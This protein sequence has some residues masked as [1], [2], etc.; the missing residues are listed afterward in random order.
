MSSLL[1]LMH[2]TTS[3]RSINKEKN[4]MCPRRSMQ[5]KDTSPLTF[6]TGGTWGASPQ[7]S[8]P[9]RAAKEPIALKVTSPFPPGNKWQI[10]QNSCSGHTVQ[11][12]RP[13]ALAG[14]RRKRLHLTCL[15]T[16]RHGYKRLYEPSHSASKCVFL[17]QEIQI[18]FL[19]TVYKLMGLLSL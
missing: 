7:L 4:L 17:F 12:P 2:T 13:T 1:F 16:D 14:R 9:C 18:A 8:T 19:Y 11:R 6:C 3:N 10:S 5:R 15:C